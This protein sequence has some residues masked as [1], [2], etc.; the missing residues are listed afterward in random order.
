VVAKV[1]DHVIAADPGVTTGLAWC[2][3][4]RVIGVEGSPIAGP[5]QRD[6]RYARLFEWGEV[7]GTIAE[8]AS[9]MGRGIIGLRCRVLVSE[10]SDHFLQR[11]RQY[12]LTSH[13]LVPIK[14]VGAYSALVAI[15][16]SQLRLGNKKAWSMVFV[17]QTPSQAKSVITNEMLV[18][19]GFPLGK[20]AAKALDMEPMSPHERDAVKHLLLFIRRMYS[21][22]STAGGFAQVI[23]GEL[24]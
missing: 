5:G 10:E 12:A 7:T 3:L 9:K 21:S 15:Q 11:K 2:E 19:W 16:N 8:Q 4:S 18:G 13:S 1:A 14:L 20:R 17:G 24:R 6:E 23:A 22:A